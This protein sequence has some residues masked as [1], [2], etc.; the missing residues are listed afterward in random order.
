MT[1]AGQDWLAICRRA[2]SGVEAAL[3]RYPDIADR[4]VATGSRGEGGDRTL[5]IDSAAEDAIFAELESVG[6]GLT[7]VSE[8]RGHVPI[9]GGG[10]V[11][12][13]IDPIDGSRNAR[14]RM[15][16]H[17]VSI[18]VADDATMGGVAF[19]YV[20]DL[21]C[22]EEWSA[23]RGGGAHLDG[24]PLAALPQDA[25]LEVLALE[26]VRAPDA[27]RTGQAL[28]DTGAARLRALGSVAL[29]LCFV[30]AGRFDALVTLSACRSVDA[31][32]G[33]LIVR[34]AGGAV[35]WT[36]TGDDPLEASLGLDM[37][38]PL[39]AA[40]SADLVD[41]LRPLAAV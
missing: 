1:P 3:E 7:A 4:S 19:G 41:R 26:M 5:V 36:E 39:I 21:G 40:A 31:A 34:E 27:A 28:S 15:P 29:S 8:E 6:V 2:A 23:E 9:G 13:V 14:R 38:S 20:K 33:Q 12:V 37:R 35:A 10:P 32:A 24:E 18:A 30:A 17:A 22:G 11:H 25:E 16:L